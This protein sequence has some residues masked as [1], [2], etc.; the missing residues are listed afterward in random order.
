MAGDDGQ[1]IVV[2][3]VQLDGD[4]GQIGDQTFAAQDR[5]RRRDGARAIEDLGDT[6]EQ[7]TEVAGQGAR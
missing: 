4:R 7:H 2:K 1:Q 6:V 3:G 5:G